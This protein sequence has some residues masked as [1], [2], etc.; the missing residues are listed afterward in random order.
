VVEGLDIERG[1]GSKELGFEGK[2]GGIVGVEEGLA[3]EMAAVELSDLCACGT[4]G[5]D[6]LSR[7]VVGWIEG[8]VIGE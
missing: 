3:D 1:D 7:G 5:M 4:G 6:R 8:D 2:V